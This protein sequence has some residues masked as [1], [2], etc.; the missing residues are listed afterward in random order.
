MCCGA[1]ELC[2]DGLEEV[3]EVAGAE[4]AGCCG[5]AREPCAGISCGAGVRKAAGSHNVAHGPAPFTNGVYDTAA[6]LCVHA[7]STARECACF[8]EK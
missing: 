4:S 3:L 6:Q 8:A 5:G 2:Q 7:A 1:W